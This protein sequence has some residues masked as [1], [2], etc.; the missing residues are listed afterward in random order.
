MDSV[1]IDRNDYDHILYVLDKRANKLRRG[2]FVLIYFLVCV[3]A[4]VAIVAYNIKKTPNSPLANAISATL[5]SRKEKDIKVALDDFF[6]QLSSTNLQAGMVAKNTLDSNVK[7]SPESQDKICRPSQS[8]M[9][10]WF[11]KSTPEKSASEKIAESIASIIISLSVFMFIGFA[12]RTI[13]VFIKYYMQ[14]GTDYDNQKIA[15]MLSKGEH[16]KFSK[17]LS[18][19]RECNIN[20][21]K[22]PPLPQ[23]K[24]FN[25]LLDVAKNAT[26]GNT[27]S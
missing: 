7:E 12:L 10:D 9:D 22:T 27:K 18:L 14:L 13:L 24:I 26:S 8:F 23:E 15:F 25:G 2:V 1:K 5:D 17:T 20:F 16:D 11:I 6:N 21:E 4:C 3:V 19:L